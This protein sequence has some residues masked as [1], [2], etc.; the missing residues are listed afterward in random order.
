M[1]IAF[2]YTDGRLRRVERAKSGTAATDSF[3]GSEELKRK[4]HHVR[5]FELSSYIPSRWIRFAGDWLWFHNLTPHKMYGELLGQM[6]CVLPLLVGYD[7]VVVS[8]SSTAYALASW[9]RIGFLKAEILAV[10]C[11][12][13]NYKFTASQRFWTRHLQRLMWS[14][15]YGEGEYD[16]FCKFLGEKLAKRVMIN[17]CGTDTTFWTPGGE[18]EGFIFSIGNDGR[19]DHELLIRVARRIGLPF[20]LVT[21]NEIK[22]AIPSNVRLIKGDLRKEILSDEE[23]RDLYRRASMVVVPLTE[24]YQPSGQSVCLQAMAC[25]KPVILTRTK[26]LWSQVKMRDKVNVIMVPSGDED[27]LGKSIKLLW[28][29]PDV[30]HEIGSKGLETVRKEWDMAGYA[31]RIEAI[32]HRIV[33]Q[34]CCV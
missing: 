17:E 19:R 7:V 25:G 21:R 6:K 15:L 8:G 30:R 24:S 26:G 20:V 5:L 1:R 16:L 11:G 27:E 10:Q 4:G 13:M 2:L 34:T 14:M 33:G 28:S 18:E 32:C 9:K 29:R 22:E 31:D 23:V 3:H 12:M